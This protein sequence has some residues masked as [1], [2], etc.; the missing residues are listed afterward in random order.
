MLLLA[1][2]LTGVHLGL[3]RALAVV[4]LGRVRRAVVRNTEIDAVARAEVVA[5]SQLPDLVRL[6][7]LGAEVVADRIEGVGVGGDGVVG[8]AAGVA[9]EGVDRGRE[10]EEEEDGER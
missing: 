9:A 4:D 3:Q 1:P 8:V 2:M 5:L 7:E 6:L 10:G